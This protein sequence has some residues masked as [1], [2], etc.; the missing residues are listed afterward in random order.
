MADSMPPP[1]PPSL[2]CREFLGIHRGY[3]SLPGEVLAPDART[4]CQPHAK[5]RGLR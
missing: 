4:Y 2:P 1:T 3:C 5:E